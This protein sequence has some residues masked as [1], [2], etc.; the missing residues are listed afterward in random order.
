VWRPGE[1][2]A[3]SNCP[4]SSVTPRRTSSNQTTAFGSVFNVID[5]AATAEVLALT[6][7][8][9]ADAG[10]LALAAGFFLWACA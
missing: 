2:F 8:G 3:I 5:F 10:L 7:A 6:D 4:D 9:R 1:T